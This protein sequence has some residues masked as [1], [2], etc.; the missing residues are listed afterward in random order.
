MKK[1]KNLLDNPKLLFKNPDY[2]HKILLFDVETAP[3]LSYV[4]GRWE[5]NIL[6]VSEHWYMICFAYKWLG[7]K[8]TY[9]YSLPDFKTYKK[10]PV[11]D[12]LLITKLWELFDQAE[13]IIG[14]NLDAFD[15]KK[16]N[17]RF[18]KHG[19]EPPSFYKTIDTLK[20]ARR[21]FKFDSNK[22]DDLGDYLS[23]GRKIQT[24][25]FNLWLGCMRGDK[26]AWKRMTDYNKMDVILLEKVYLKLRG[27][28]TTTPNMNLILGKYSVCPTCGSEHIT[29]R[30][31]RYTKVYTYQAYHCQNCG[32]RFQG[33][34]VDRGKPNFK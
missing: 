31:Y 6:S 25:G 1:Y 4:W 30:G 10:D 33:E 19:L 32:R 34:R 15:I 22:L 12:E 11:N 16:S 17:A 20:I 14:Q 13:I 5:Q 24:G 9:V 2:G 29:K 8:K 28:A 21:N 27:W 26:K 3:N 7:E 18:I 23:I